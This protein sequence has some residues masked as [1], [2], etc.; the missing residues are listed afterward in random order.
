MAVQELRIYN[1]SNH[2]T[3]CMAE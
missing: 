2:K 3:L 1:I